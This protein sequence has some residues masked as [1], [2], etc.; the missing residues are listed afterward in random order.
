MVDPITLSAL[1]GSVATGTASAIGA[2]IGKDVYR[3]VSR[4]LSYCQCSS[5]METIE[6]FHNFSFPFHW[7]AW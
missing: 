6:A 1:A 2:E 7:S 5:W 3:A 4:G